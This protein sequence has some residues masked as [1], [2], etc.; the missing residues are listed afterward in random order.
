MSFAKIAFRNIPR[1]KLR[2]SLTIIGIIIAV[3][4][5]VGV[6]IAAESSF[7]EFRNYI[8]AAGGKIDI[9][10]TTISGAAFEQ[11]KVESSTA[12]LGY[13][14]AAGRV[15]ERGL[16]KRAGETKAVSVTGVDHLKDFEYNGYT[17]EG[18]GTL[19][20]ND[21]TIGQKMS[22]DLGIGVGDY[23]TIQMS[24]G[25]TLSVHVVG[26]AKTRLETGYNVYIDLPFA[27][28]KLGYVGRVTY[29]IVHVTDETRLAEVRR[30][31]EHNLGESYGVRSTK[32]ETIN[33]VQSNL[34]GWRQ[35][36]SSISMVAVLVSIGLVLNTMYMNLGERTYEV[37]VLRA[38]G[39]RRRDIFWLFFSE[40]IFYALIGIAL[41]IGAGIGF[42]RII[43]SFT[44]I[45]SIFG[46]ESTGILVVKPEYII[47][48]ATTGLL[49]TI[50]G[51]F[52]PSVSAARTGILKA[53]KPE[54]RPPG[55]QRTAVR[56]LLVGVPLASLGGYVSTL[57][58]EVGM[59]D[60]A[61]LVIGLVMVVSGILRV[62]EPLIERILSPLKAVGKLL[63]KN[64]GRNLRRAAITYAVI[65][66]CVAFLVMMGG[67]RVGMES[68]VRD[69]VSSYFGADIMVFAGSPLPAS[70]SKSIVQ[71]DPAAV[72]AVTSLGITATK[73]GSTQIGV[74]SVDPDTFPLVFDKFEFSED[75]PKDLYVQL[76]NNLYSIVLVEPL[77]DSLKVKVGQQI[78]V[79]TP[80]GSVKLTVVGIV[81]GTGLS[82]AQ[83]GGVPLSQSGFVSLRTAST[84]FVPTS[85]PPKAMLF[86]VRMREGAD[87]TQVMNEIHQKY[88]TMY[89]LDMITVN[90]LTA[91]VETQSG[92]F[93]VVFDIIVYMAI[94]SATAGISATM[95]MN[96]NE[97]RR[98]IGMLRSQG[99]SSRQI[100]ML[101]VAEAVFLGLAGYVVGAV[102][103]IF[104]LRGT[105]SVM[106]GMGLAVP[107]L[108][109]W[110]RMQFALFLAVGISIAGVIYPSFRATQVRLIEVLRYRG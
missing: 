58:M 92:R 15:S 96:V 109:P 57:G 102:A 108:V 23:I 43:Y 53:L 25:S 34:A 24:G 13:V 11:R 71:V 45:V 79:R 50:I 104:L 3:A 27:Q 46:S 68:A 67:M 42:A 105:V 32:E 98:E 90:D 16:I 37:G 52:L 77:A 1:R 89:E 6:D 2:N 62:G 41:G 86:Y 48:G 44:S 103:G 97:R 49:A 88:G 36:L 69:T 20:R 28:Q 65:A 33:F 75:T 101:V 78:P 82:M 29:A 51:G 74:I 56:L 106:S 7:V 63:S 54:I 26:V 93:F 72:E 35:G 94:I 81:R 31:L 83:I 84:Y 9:V 66:M 64:L 110:E 60:F 22:D 14:Q 100:F 38:I 107:F 85:G 95:L 61:L 21:V 87:A 70:F 55:R 80:T 19:R 99:M 40:T 8:E 59:L 5:P 47:S 12:G 4:L 39:A 30:M 76:K 73:S 10:V 18:T 91:E 17:F